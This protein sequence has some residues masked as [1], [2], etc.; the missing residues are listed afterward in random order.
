MVTRIGGADEA[1]AAN[2]EPRGSAA[3]PAAPARGRELQLPR[4]E[5][6]DTVAAA[7]P[8]RIFS[9][10]HAYH[11]NSIDTN[12]DGETFLSA[13]DL[14][15][16][17]WHL[18][19]TRTCFNLVDLKPDDMEDLN[20]VITSA[21][22]DPTTCHTLAYS[23]SRGV[24]RI[25]DMRASAHC[26][27]CAR[28]LED[29]GANRSSFFS[30]VISSISDL[31]F[32]NDGRHVLAR[33]VRR[34]GR[35]G[36]AL[37]LTRRAH[38]P[39][40]LQLKLWDVAMERAPVLTIDVHEALRS[41]LVELYENDSIFDKFECNLCDDRQYEALPVPPPLGTALNARPTPAAE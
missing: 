33:G 11:I 35:C 41:R 12:C 16:N 20:E 22:F 31:R 39:D 25:C 30:E 6:H 3:G 14:R 28:A 4:I 18:N 32:S 15:V 7:A 38:V 37:G 1:L 34:L 26:D 19:D 5:A 9:N 24:V 21:L 2:G 27:R 13:D 40:Y 23:T 8:K 10:G 36:R 17:W 29:G